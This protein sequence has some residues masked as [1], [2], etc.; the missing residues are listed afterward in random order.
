MKFFLNTGCP[1]TIYKKNLQL[2]IQF[3]IVKMPALIVNHRA[4]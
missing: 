1:G 3:Y 2:E 4:L